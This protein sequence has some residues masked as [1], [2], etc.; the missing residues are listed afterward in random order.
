MTMELH[1]RSAPIDGLPCPLPD[2][3]D[4]IRAVLAPQISSDN[5]DPPRTTCVVDL[6]LDTAELDLSPLHNLP[7]T[8]SVDSTE[9]RAADREELPL[10]RTRTTPK[11]KLVLHSLRDRFDEQILAQFHEVLVQQF[12]DCD[13]LED[14]CEG[15]KSGRE[16]VLSCVTVSEVDHGPLNPIRQTLNRQTL[17]DEVQ[18]HGVDAVHPLSTEMVED[19]HQQESCSPSSTSPLLNV[20]IL[21]LEL[22]NIYSQ[23][24]GQEHLPSRGRTTR[25]SRRGTGASSEQHEESSRRET[26]VA[27][28]FLLGGLVVEYFPRARAGLLCYIMTAPEFRDCGVARFLHSKLEEVALPRLVAAGVGFL[29]GGPGRRAPP[30][31]GGA[32]EDN[33]QVLLFAEVGLDE[34]NMELLDG[35]LP[36]VKTG[37]TREGGIRAHHVALRRLGYSQVVMPYFPPLLPEQELLLLVH[38]GTSGSSSRPTFLDA[39]LSAERIKTFVDALGAASLGAEESATW[40]FSEKYGKMFDGSKD[41][42]EQL[43]S[44]QGDASL[45]QT[46]R[47]GCVGVRGMLPWIPR[48]PTHP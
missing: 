19:V 1:P 7:H 46:L 48:T 37:T 29:A 36:I 32:P 18:R 14:W 33:E 21:E 15:L 24:R 39:Q 2:L 9:D 41:P 12:P 13:D 10:P 8:S 28:R 5:V 26:L 43:Q 44:R 6:D 42:A 27:S 23:E 25:R 31:I 3:R 45:D 11:P 38:Q 35:K 20:L 47:D 34:H 4:A 16:S 22:E 30:T 40:R 17:G